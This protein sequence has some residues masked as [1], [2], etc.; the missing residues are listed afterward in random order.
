MLNP[1]YLYN[2]GDGAVEI[3]NHM[4][5]RILATI[6][7][8]VLTRARRGDKYI[9]TARDKWLIDTL[10][11]SGLLLNKITKIIADHT[12]YAYS[13]I[14]AAM[15]DAGVK[16]LTWDEQIYIK[17]GLD[18]IRN[19]SL[20]TIA[21]KAL[22]AQR[23]GE[24]NISPMGAD[25]APRGAFTTDEEVRA[26]ANRRARRLIKQSPYI[27]RLTERDYNATLGEFRNMTQ[28]V[29]YA[30]INAF[31]RA[32]DEAYERTA[33]GECGYAQAIAEAAQRI[34]DEGVV[35]TNA[36]GRKDTPEAATLRCVRTGISKM[37]SDITVERAKE[38]GVDHF[39]VSSHLGARYGDKGNNPTNHWWWQGKVYQWVGLVPG[40]PRSEYPDF[41]ECTG[42]G[43]IEGLCGINCR[44]SFGPFIDGMAN[45]AMK[46]DEEENEKRYDLEQKARAQERAIRASKVRIQGL[47]AEVDNL[48]AGPEKDAAETALRLAEARLTEQN[49]GYNAFCKAN[50]L[51][52]LTERL[53][54]AQRERRNNI[55]LVDNNG[56]A[57]DIVIKDNAIVS[58]STN[59]SDKQY[60]EG[61]NKAINGINTLDL[62][63]I[64]KKNEGEFKFTDDAAKTCYSRSENT[65]HVNLSDDANGAYGG[66]KKPYQSMLH[67]IGHNLDDILGGH[68]GIN[69]YM[70][71]TWNNGQMLKD[72]EQDINDFLEQHK[73][74]LF[75]IDLQNPGMT[76]GAT[77]KK[78]LVNATGI[79][80][81]EVSKF[82]GA[83]D[84]I[85]S[86]S[87]DGKILGAGHRTAYWTTYVEHKRASEFFAHCIESEV[88]GDDYIKVMKTVFP[89]AYNDYLQIIKEAANK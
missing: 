52:P 11:E 67:E 34:C 17:A 66:Y 29:A 8:A 62:K 65:I 74:G 85:G 50:N 61:L 22:E 89:K 19:N 2:I 51:R 86:F 41:I 81:W 7:E 36:A 73:I 9:L 47:K 30:A 24:L 18:S 48:P 72:M 39:M 71:K 13:E 15:V 76:G 57:S 63:A 80:Q 4:E 25:G 42:Y 84:I 54:V 70:S 21:Q 77:L 14:S 26:E 32:T 58:S 20:D 1:K 53:Q 35:L 82:G 59:I 45:N 27:R 60:L 49:R 16:A 79:N 75:K 6:I 83:A 5:Q 23:R 37:A 68:N 3:T 44:H 69:N 31:T 78:M 12:G 56:D 43:S 28:S 64:I 33:R 87:S 10:Q 38:M 46:Y 88:A 55:N 40:N